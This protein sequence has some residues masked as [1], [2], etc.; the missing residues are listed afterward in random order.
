[1]VLRARDSDLERKG[2]AGG[3]SHAV[4]LLRACVGEGSEAGAGE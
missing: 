3:E 1:M 4:C 2:G